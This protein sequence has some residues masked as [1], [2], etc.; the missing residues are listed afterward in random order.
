MIVSKKK[1]PII[2][3]FLT[4]AMLFSAC[5][6]SAS[7]TITEPPVGSASQSNSIVV[8]DSQKGQTTVSPVPSETVTESAPDLAAK[9]PAETPSKTPT[10]QP[11]GE[12]MVF[13]P[14]IGDFPTGINPLTG[15]PASDPSLLNLPAILISIPNFP[16]S[17]R[18][19]AGISF[20]PWIFEIYIG[21]G[22]TRFLSAFYGEEPAVEPIVNGSCAVR[23]SP[24]VPG[25]VVLGD[26][27]WLDQN[28]DGIQN[29]NEIGIG[30]ICVTLYDSKGNALQTTS[31]DSNGYYGF[32]VDPGEGYSLGFEKPNGL[33]FTQA[34]VGFDNQ[35]S[36]VDPSSGKTATFSL[37]ASDQNWDAGYI[38]TQNGI[39]SQAPPTI[40][41]EPTNSQT[42]TIANI[43]ALP[44]VE[45]G[46]I[47]SMRLPYEQIARFFQ[48]GCIVS[49]SGDPN[50]LAQVPGCE[51]VL[52]DN[53]SV[54]DAKLNL[55]QLQ[56]LAANNKPNYPI[57]YSGNLFDSNA[58]SGGSLAS[59]LNVKWNWQNQSEFRFDP[60]S[61]AYQRFANTPNNPLDFTPQ[62]DKLT[63]EQLLFD[64]VIVI[65]VDYTAY[66]ET[67]MNIN[68][69]FGTMGRAD[70]FR[71][72]QV[73]HIFWSTIAQ[74]YE[75]ETQHTRP[76]RF[77]DSQG[78]PF[79]L[80]PGHTWVNVF[81]NSSVTYEK[82]PGEG[83]W[84][85]EFH[86]P[87]VP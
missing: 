38:Q 70:L 66:A 25:P 57:N 64:N 7:P 86:P 71:S 22:E 13:G 42:D 9:V 44:P 21:Y 87:I 45:I 41:E 63:G 78:N 31:T 59:L 24:F 72:G 10:P 76:I 46:P 48:G 81:T 68:L 2:I 53:N 20:A 14:Q 29:S 36:D 54:N 69:P 3:S 65:Y 56:T 11:T 52:G 28:H 32:N 4:V 16:V 47:R 84:T 79:P 26:R 74:Q 80:S 62:T 1:F 37:P 15:L 75:Q 19:Q 50:V 43:A 82:N 35:D 49:A 33:E 73:Y 27:V 23:S 39:T 30:G 55:T 5:E 17:A 77:T 51:Y 6:Q 40:V 60:L 85:G 18:P 61:G 34:N 67:L 12:N 83:V 8:Q 58:P